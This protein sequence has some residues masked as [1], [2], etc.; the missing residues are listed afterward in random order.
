MTTY[1]ILPHSLHHSHKLEDFLNSKIEISANS[2]REAYIK[3]Y[4]SDKT[5]HLMSMF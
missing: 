1:K 5:R 3:Y 2:A 4:N